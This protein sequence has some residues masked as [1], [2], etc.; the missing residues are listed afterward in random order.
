MS[1]IPFLLLSDSPTAKTGLGRITRDIATRMHAHM[2]DVFRVATI[3]YGGPF[4]SSLGFMQYPMDSE[5][6][7]VTNLKEVWE[8]FSQG[9]KGVVMTVWDASRLQWLGRPEMCRDHKTRDFLTKKPFK[10]WGY[11][12][13]DATGIGN[14]LTSVIN[15]TMD[16]FDRVLA[17]SKWSEEIFRRGM[18]DS[19]GLTNLPHGI[20]TS[21]FHPRDRHTARHGFGQKQ[22]ARYTAG[23]RQGQFIAIPDDALMVGVVATNQARKDWAMA[24]AILNELN[25]KKHLRAWLHTDHIT[26]HWN[27]D[28]LCQDFGLRDPLIVTMHEPNDETM[29]W[30]YAACDLTLGIGLGEGFGFPIF[31]SLACGVPCFH[32]NYAGAPEHMNPKMLVEP[33]MY[34][35]DGPFNLVRPVYEVDRWVEVIKNWLDNAEEVKLPEH[36]DWNVLWPQWEKWL[37]E[38]IL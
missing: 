5:E 18:N 37:R 35:I 9:Q 19:E 16:G 27:F 3:G 17:Y 8:D 26:R 38:G 32:G 34:R 29:A 24:F 22:G 30:G 33:S 13:Q 25:Q 4:S 28:R 2:S 21:V 12:P 23:K 10:R 36:L 11:F 14:K 15:H 6:F 31:E 1:Q 20:D 7:C